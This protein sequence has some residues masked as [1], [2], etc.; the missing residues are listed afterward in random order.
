MQKFAKVKKDL[1]KRKK[2]QTFKGA[3]I[4][5]SFFS[6]NRE[7]KTLIKM[8]CVE[9]FNPI[10]NYLFVKPL[11]KGELKEYFQDCFFNWPEMTI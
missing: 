7:F 6:N 1:G 5:S 2:R 9:Y 8:P 4:V 10:R 11:N 3:E